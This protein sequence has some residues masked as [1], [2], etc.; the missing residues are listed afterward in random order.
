M[1]YAINNEWN[2]LSDFKKDYLTNFVNG[3]NIQ[4]PHTVKKI[5]LNYFDK[6]DY[7]MICTYQKTINYVVNKNEKIYITFD[8]VMLSCKVYLNGHFIDEHLGGYTEFT[9]DIS[10]HFKSGEDNLLTVVVDTHEQKNIPPFGGVVDYLTY[11]G[12]YREVNI[13]I[14]PTI[15]FKHVLV[16]GDMNGLINIKY[17]LNNV[18]NTKYEIEYK[19]IK[20]GNVIETFTEDEHQYDEA[21]LWDVDN[22]HL[23]H[24]EATVKSKYGTDTK[25]VRFGFRS[26]F[27]TKEGFYLNGKYMKLIGLNRHQSYAY[28]GYAMP[29]SM[30]EEDALLLKNKLGVNYVRCSHYPMSKHFLN[31]CDEL[32][33]LLLEEIPG[34]QHVSKEEGWRKVHL[35][36]VEEMITTLFNHP[37]IV[38]WGVR[39]NEGPDDHELYV[40]ANRIAKEID[41]YRHTGG[42]RNFK[43]SELL[44]DVYTYN[45]FFHEGDNH[46]LDNPRSV[47]KNAPYLVTEFNGHMFPTKAFDQE[48]RLVEHTL[49]HARVLDAMYQNKRICGCSGWCMND[50]NTHKEFGSGDMICYHGVNDIFRNEKYAA[51]IYSAQQD[52]FPVLKVLSILTGGEKN[53]CLQGATLVNTNADYIEFY[54]NGKYINSFYPNKDK[55]KYL[56]HPPIVID[57]YIGSVVLD[58]NIF[59]KKDALKVTKVLNYGIC[60]GFNKTVA[61]HVFTLLGIVLKYRLSIAK[62][63]QI[64]TNFVTSWGDESVE[65]EVRAIKD[66]EVVGVEKF[67]A[68]TTFKLVAE[69]KVELNIEETYDVRKINVKVVDQYNQLLRFCFE[70]I[71]IKVSGD[72]ELLS[73]ELVSLQAGQIGVYIKSKKAGKGKVVIKSRFNEYTVLVTVNDKN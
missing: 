54:K 18:K 12:I 23:Y 34:W 69:D 41:P 25:L 22:P 4:I 8:G 42:V 49:R 56:P 16:N 70:P 61:K 50:Y 40:E 38:V 36:Q 2:F 59:K 31:K 39:I 30:Q 45:D 6:K 43:G 71:S 19:L 53:A 5:P 35:Q 52:R 48:D 64:V 13:E 9:F 57:D 11:G 29:K 68:A 33:L 65:Y 44:E 21:L 73:P 3:E 46:G 7:E 47:C 27:F 28:V 51:S 66:N 62:L 63:V 17:E 14:K 37:S 15:N 58:S 20:D 10:K 1:R 67:G 26:A 55:F 24:I 32:G 72:I 60:H